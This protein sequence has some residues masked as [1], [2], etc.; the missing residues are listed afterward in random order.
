MLIVLPGLSHVAS[1]ANRRAI[2]HGG[3][4]GG[5]KPEDHTAP[6]ISSSTT[7]GVVVSVGQESW[8]SWAASAALARVEIA[9]GHLGPSHQARYFP[10]TGGQVYVR[11]SKAHPIDDGGGNEERCDERHSSP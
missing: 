11:T 9:I 6:S 4:S 1:L 2:L 3:S 8:T 7:R 5:D 10:D